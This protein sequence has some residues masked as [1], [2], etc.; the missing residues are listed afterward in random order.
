M[1]V[2]YLRVALREDAQLVGA[3]ESDLY[4]RV[5]ERRQCSDRRRLTALAAGLAALLVGIA[6]PVSLNA[7]QRLAEPAQVASPSGIEGHLGLPTRG[8]LADDADFIEQVRQLPW[9]V[10]DG[11]PPTE[12]RHVVFAGDVPGQRWAL[13]AGSLDN[14]TVVAAWFFGPI[15]AEATQLAFN[16]DQRPVFHDQPLNVVNTD[17]PEMAL[18]VI[19]APGDVV[20][21]SRYTYI[22]NV[23][24]IY[25]TYQPLDTVDGVAVTSV[26]ASSGGIGASVTVT[27][28]GQRLFRGA[29]TL[30][31]PGLQPELTAI[32]FDD[33]RDLAELVPDPSWIAQGFAGL[34]APIGIPINELSPV[35]LFGG[36]IPGTPGWETTAVIVAITV[37]SGATAVS[38]MVY[39]S[40][41]EQGGAIVGVTGESYVLPSGLL[42]TSGLALRVGLPGDGSAPAPVSLLIIAP[43]QF[44]TAQPLG[45]GDVPV[46]AEIALNAGL[47]LVAYPDSTV[48]VALAGSAGIG[49]IVEIGEGQVFSYPDNGP[50]YTD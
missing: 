2:D 40:R 41:I 46:G 37:P 18:V 27:R 43:V 28:D 35:L 13:V 17:N 4:D 26:D 49:S 33:P 5:R 16:Y 11:V 44:N 23:G 34:A 10:P 6:I 12:S 36:P 50:G 42:D 22:D 31:G 7:L 20:E 15:G 25:R 32:D 21:I 38:S 3:P 48:R 30:F 19:T 1:D 24:G 29:P 47:A 39:A 14:G 8:S 9:D 45:P